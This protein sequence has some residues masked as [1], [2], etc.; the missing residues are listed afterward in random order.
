MQYEAIRDVSD[1]MK[2][3]KPIPL[4]VL[5]K[6]VREATNIIN[7]GSTTQFYYREDGIYGYNT[8]NPLGVTRYN[9][10]G[11]GFSQD[12]GKTFQTAM[13][14]LGIVANAITAGT[15]NTNN[16]SVFGAKDGEST[17]I[18]GG[19][20]RSTGSFVRTFPQGLAEYES[21]TESWNGTYRSGLISKTSGGK[22]QTDITRWLSLNDKSITTQREIHSASPDKRG[23]RFIDFF[24]EETY[25][26]DVYGQGMHIY[27][28]QDLKI[29]AGYR[30]SFQ[31]S[32]SWYTQFVG[33]GVEADNDGASLIL[34]R[35]TSFN[36]E[37]GKGGQYISLQ[38]FDG[39]EHG[40]LGILSDN[41]HLSLKSSFGE[42]H[43]RGT[44]AKVL[45]SEGTSLSSI[46]AS[47][48][49]LSG[50]ANPEPLLIPSTFHQARC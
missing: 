7:A 9:A 20:I 22:T 11:I 29:E 48:F 10:N 18:E 1:I 37:I 12:G 45:N 2:G 6:A 49:D 24:A 32:N 43:L 42:V 40:H 35:Q 8:N 19:K 5:P 28:G 4:S 3:K 23:A 13:T 41:R 17:Q 47:D 27:S 36:S 34:K 46:T 39:A 21:Y 16:V 31:S 25:S 44:Q 15:I 50:V 14:Y 30:L 33:G 38:A 26:S